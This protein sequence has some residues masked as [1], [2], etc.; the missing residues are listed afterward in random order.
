MVRT[1]GE[2]PDLEES[3]N[4]FKNEGSTFINLGM[5]FADEIVIGQESQATPVYVLRFDYAEAQKVQKIWQNTIS[6]FE[7]NFIQRKESKQYLC[8]L[9]PR[10]ASL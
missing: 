2:V 5:E 7:K 6:S 1:N 3:A 9:L 4:K 8:S 10:W